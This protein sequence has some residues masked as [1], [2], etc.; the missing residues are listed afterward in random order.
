M[1]VGMEALDQDH[2]KLI[3][4]ILRLE[5]ARSNDRAALREILDSLIAYAEYHFFREESVMEACG[6]PDVETHRAIHRQFAERVYG[7]HADDLDGDPVARDSV[8]DYLKDWLRH[9]ILLED[10][11]YRPHVVDCL[12]AHQAA[13][14]F[15]SLDP[16]ADRPVPNP[17]RA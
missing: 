11:D 8:L 13:A 12:E 3:D 9:H 16:D 15:G 1:S 14:A 2:R 6:Y 10:M 7:W 17:L 5:A 4:M